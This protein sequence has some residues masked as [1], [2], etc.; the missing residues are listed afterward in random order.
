V[1]RGSGPLFV[2]IHGTPGFWYDWR[3]QLPALARHFRVV[4]ID[5]RGFNLSDRP[6]GVPSYAREQLVGDVEAVLRHFGESRAILVGHDSGGWI[7]WSYAM[8][9]PQRT[10]RFVILN[11]PHPGCLER[12]L[13]ASPRQYEASA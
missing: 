13:A 1:A 12:E 10:S 7:E 3:H 9:H 6:E 5:Q 11:L 2:L 4:A 8:C